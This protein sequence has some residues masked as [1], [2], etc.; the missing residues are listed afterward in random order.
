MKR[1]IPSSRTTSICLMIMWHLPLSWMHT[2]SKFFD[3]FYIKISYI[4]RGVHLHHPF[5]IIRHCQSKIITVIEKANLANN[6]VFHF[7]TRCVPFSCHLIY[8]IADDSKR[9]MYHSESSYHE[10]GRRREE[11]FLLRVISYSGVIY[12]NKK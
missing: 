12:L 8:F 1:H 4:P 10:S 7:I 2:R 11:Y 9:W 5:N 6:V 3:A